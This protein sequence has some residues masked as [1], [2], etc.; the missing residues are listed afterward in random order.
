MIMNTSQGFMNHSKRLVCAVSAP[1]SCCARK[2]AL[3]SAVVFLLPLLNGCGIIKRKPADATD[4]FSLAGKTI[5]PEKANEL[6]SEVGGNFAYGPGLGDAAV[7]VGTVVL[8]PP[9]AVYLIGNAAL[10]LSGYE[11]VTVSSLLPAAEGKQWSDTYDSVVSVPGKVVAAMAG[12]EYRSR[13]VADQRIRTVINDIN[14]QQT[15]VA[16]P[17]V[18]GVVARS[19]LAGSVVNDKK[20]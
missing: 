3:C 10:S 16:A 17:T 4:E 8:F 11:P 9:Y 1:S 18:R 7:T 20:P 2:L 5:P 19:F 14:S 12:H 15:T 6:L 13:Q